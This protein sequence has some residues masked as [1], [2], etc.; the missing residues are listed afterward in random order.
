MM[1]VEEL[2]GCEMEIG[3]VR[4][5]DIDREMQQAYLDYAMSVIVARAL[6]DARDGLKPV[7]RRILY[8]MDELGLRPESPYKKSARI[9]GEVLGKFHPHG[10]MAVYEAM[11]RMAQ[12]FTMRVPLVDGQGNFGSV[13]GDPPAAMRYTEARLTPAAMQMLADIDADTVDFVANFDD[14]LR[15]PTVLPAA[16]PNLLVNGA[17]G[18]AVG[19]STSIPPHNLGEVI[20]ALRYL[21]LNWERMDDITIEDLMQ[22]IQGPDFPTGGIILP[23]EGEHSLAS[24]YG[25]GRGQVVVRARAHLEE[26]ERGRSR[27]IVTELPYTVNK[28]A[29]IERIAE[30]V[31]EEKIVG[32]TDLRDES[33]QRGMR[34]VIEVG[35]NAEAERVLA[36][37]YRHTQMQS[38]FSIIL[39]ALVDGEPR[40]LSLKQALRVYLDHR[41]AVIRRRSEYELRRARERAHILEGLR[42][43][44]K[45][46]DEVIGL[47]RKSPDAET[48]R[49]RLMR[50][51]KLSEIQAQA[52]LDMPLR[53][54]AALERKK[55]ELEYQQVLARI[56]ELEALLRSAPKM[57]ALA[58]EELAAVKEAFA[59]RRRTQIAAG[60]QKGP[61]LALT[62]TDLA[63]QGE[64]WVS[65]TSDGLI[66]RSEDGKPPRLSGN[67]SPAFLL[68]ASSRDTVYLVAQNGEC[69][70]LALHSLPPSS[71]PSSGLPI[72]DVSPLK[73][74]KALAAVFA[75]PP[76][77]ERPS[78]AYVLTVTRQGYVKKSSLE[79]VSGPAAH[80]LTLV[81]VNPGDR[82]GWVQITRGDR[83]ILLVTAQGMAIRFSEQ[84]VRPM[85]LVAAGVLG[86]KLSPN[87]EVIG[88]ETLPKTG[89]ILLVASDG[90]AKRVAVEQFPVQGR[91][92]QGVQAWKLTP[93]AQLV[94]MA[95]GKATDQATLFLEKLAPKS[96]RFDE[97]PLQT[98]TGRGR[99]IQELKSGD[100]ITR[101][102]VVWE[103][104]ADSTSQPTARPK[105]R[106]KALAEP[107]QIPAPAEKPPRTAKKAPTPSTPS[108]RTRR[109]T[110]QT[111]PAAE[112][113]P[114]LK[115][116]KP[117]RKKEPAT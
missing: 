80:L 43:A 109:S 39:L 8:A 63:P 111:Q 69:A 27:I 30:L 50:R 51:F 101:L 85:G 11:A 18:I 114:P 4:Q 99:V 53:R 38:A 113:L 24:A 90:K 92:G 79:E 82:L 59:E 95:V 28:A 74:A 20:D 71:R 104:G 66:S 62:V 33:D 91:Y 10:D 88:A 83:E 22:F 107:Q 48:A 112:S 97:A 5:V 21:L 23:S 45:N 52:I 60:L 6:P 37:L 1:G 77:G 47:I 72:G 29:L 17:T 68:K 36:E 46:L 117:S 86:I 9:V 116:A 108:R 70:A 35:K 56:K 98:R 19:M 58:A 106:R 105:G 87:D 93:S 42:V 25:S 64:H 57:R 102:S 103:L 94:G 78:D 16:F 49:G 100:R 55:I 115:P 65:V 14:T 3:L 40:L 89:D 73:D 26:M 110:T 41:L 32:I 44:L 76:K 2:G 12:P 34:I 61:A 67:E 84:S 13:D 75:L 15:E 7:H 96:I 54:L 31:R 81:K